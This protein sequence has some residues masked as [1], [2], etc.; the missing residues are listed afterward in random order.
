MW[1]ADTLTRGPGLLGGLHSACRPPTCLSHI[2]SG[3]TGLQPWTWPPSPSPTCFLSPASLFILSSSCSLP[4]IQLPS[5]SKELSLLKSQS[6]H[7]PLTYSHL[8]RTS[9]FHLLSDHGGSLIMAPSTLLPSHPALL[10]QHQRRLPKVKTSPIIQ[11]SLCLWVKSHFLPGYK[12]FH[13]L[14]PALFQVSTPLSLLC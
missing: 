5:N 8:L 3:C 13:G 14:S 6:A 4:H 12:V 10:S 7:V 11:G 2:T 1:W 9:Q